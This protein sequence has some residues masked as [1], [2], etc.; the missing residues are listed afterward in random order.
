[1]P[2]DIT[3]TDAK[4]RALARLANITLADIHYARIDE[5]AIDVPTR[6]GADEGFVL[7]EYEDGLLR[8]A[9]F[10]SGDERVPLTDEEIIVVAYAAERTRSYLR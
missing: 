7:Q 8:S 9:Y 6:D 4:S 2:A 5:T 1:M 10:Y 3:P